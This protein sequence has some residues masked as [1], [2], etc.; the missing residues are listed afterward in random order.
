[1]PDEK[2]NPLVTVLRY[3]ELGFILPAAVVLGYIVGRLLDY[4]LH[5]HWIYLVGVVFGAVVG[6]ISMVRMALNSEHEE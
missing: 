4:W 3:S 6:F 1:M 5:T 2:K